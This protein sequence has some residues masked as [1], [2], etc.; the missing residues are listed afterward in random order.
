MKVDVYLPNGDG[1]SV[2]VSAET[3][4]SQLRAAAQQHFQRR[5]TLI[6]KGRKLDLAASLSEARLRDGEAVAA[7]VQLGQL[8]ATGK[9]L[10]W[11]CHGGVDVANSA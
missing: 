1:R 6:A 9:A 7:V 8:A 10:A 2:E 5:L 11:H 4:I 3:P